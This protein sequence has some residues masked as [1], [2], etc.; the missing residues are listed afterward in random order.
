MCVCSGVL[1]GATPL[2]STVKSSV[3]AK[4]SENSCPRQSRFSMRVASSS[5]DRSNIPESARGRWCCRSLALGKCPFCDTSMPLNHDAHKDSKNWGEDHGWRWTGLGLRTA[6]VVS[7]C[8]GS[9]DWSAASE[10]GE[11][12]NT[13]SARLNLTADEKRRRRAA[14]NVAELRAILVP[15]HLEGC[16]WSLA[17]VHI[18]RRTI[19]YFD[20]LSLPVPK[21]LGQ[22]LTEFMAAE[23]TSFP[24][25][26]DLQVD[27]R[28]PQQKNWSD[29]GIF[30][31][32]YAECLVMDLPI[33]LDT[34]LSGIEE[35]RLA[36]ALA[37]LEGK[38]S[39]TSRET[40]YSDR[41]DLP[42]SQKWREDMKD[43]LSSM[44]TAKLTPEQKRKFKVAL[45]LGAGAYMSP[46]KEQSISAGCAKS[47]RK[48]HR[49]KVDPMKDLLVLAMVIGRF[50]EQPVST[51]EAEYYAGAS[52]ASDS[53]LLKEAIQFLTGKRTLF[54]Q[55]LHK[56]GKRIKLLLH[57]LGFQDENNEPEPCVHP[58][59]LSLFKDLGQT[60]QE[61]CAS[62]SL[63]ETGTSEE[64]EAAT[65]TAVV[66]KEL[67]D[68]M[69]KQGLNIRMLAEQIKELKGTVGTMTAEI[70][71]LRTEV[72][73]LQQR[74][75]EF[76]EEEEAAR[77]EYAKYFEEQEKYKQE[78]RADRDRLLEKEHRMEG[79]LGP[80]RSEI[81]EFS[82][83]AYFDAMTQEQEAQ[84]AMEENENEHYTQS[85]EYISEE[86][87]G[88]QWQEEEE[89]K[90]TGNLERG[91]ESKEPEKKPGQTQEEYDAERKE[92]L[93]KAR[94]AIAAKEAKRQ[95]QERGFKTPIDK[96]HDWKFYIDKEGN[97]WKQNYKTG[98]KIWWNYDYKYKHQK[99]KGKQAY[100]KAGKGHRP[101]EPFKPR[102][103]E[104][105]KYWE[106]MGKMEEEKR[107]KR[108][109]EKAV[110]EEKERKEQGA[111]ERLEKAAAE[112]EEKQKQ[113][114][115]LEKAAEENERREAERKAKEEEAAAAA[116][117]AAVKEEKARKAAAAE[118]EK[119]RKAAA[120]AAE[121][122]KKMEE[123]EAE[124]RKEQEANKEKKRIEELEKELAE[125]R[126]ET[127]SEAGSTKGEEGKTEKQ[128][129]ASSSS[130]DPETKAKGPP[131]PGQFQRG[132]PKFDEETDRNF[133]AVFPYDGN[134]YQW[135]WNGVNCFWYYYDLEQRC[136]HKQEGKDVKGKQ[137][138]LTQ[139]SRWLQAKGKKG[140]G[141]GKNKGKEEEEEDLAKHSPEYDYIE[142]GRQEAEGGQ[143]KAVKKGLQLH[144]RTDTP[145][146]LLC[147]TAPAH[148]NTPTWS[149]L[150][151]D[152]T[153]LGLWEEASKKAVSVLRTS[154]P[155]AGRRLSSVSTSRV[156][157][158]ESGDAKI[159]LHNPKENKW[160]RLRN[161]ND[162]DG[163]PHFGSWETFTAVDAG[164]GQVA[165]HCAAHN[166]YMRMPGAHALDTSSHRNAWDR[167]EGWLM[168]VAWRPA[169]WVERGALLRPGTTVALWNDVHKRYLRI[170]GHHDKTD[171]S[172][173][174]NKMA[175][176]PASWDWE[177]L[178]VVDA[179]YG[180]VALHNHVSNRFMKMGGHDFRARATGCKLLVGQW[181]LARVAE[182][183]GQAECWE[184]RFGLNL[185]FSSVALGPRD[186]I[187]SPQKNW[188]QLPPPVGWGSEKF[189]VVDAGGGK[190]ALHHA[191]HNRFLDAG[192]VSMCNHG[193]GCISPHKDGQAECWEERFGLNLAFSSVALGPRDMIRSPQKN[194]DQLPPPVGW[195]S[196]KFTVVDAG[197]GKVA[198]HHAEHN[199]FWDAG[200]VSMCN[201]GD[202][203]ISPHKAPDHLPGGWTWPVP[204]RGDMALPRP[205]VDTET[206]DT[207]TAAKQLADVEGKERSQLPDQR[208][209]KDRA[210]EHSPPTP[211]WGR[212]SDDEV[213][214]PEHS[215]QW[216]WGEAGRPSDRGNSTGIL[217]ERPRQEPAARREDGGGGARLTPNHMWLDVQ[218]V[219]E[220]MARAR[221][222]ELPDNRH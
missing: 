222:G 219:Q 159:G 153:S 110:A 91:E 185:A 114:E 151:G 47:S 8:T 147:G 76:I 186:M 174:L 20:S 163:A 126:G 45:L 178:R 78:L 24:G 21:L 165:L 146:R 56:Q 31:L 202:G 197:G 43:K 101:Q 117:A 149:G 3:Q 125:L 156:V 139:E 22:R 61:L 103:E 108:E 7:G 173:K 2:A 106:R 111:R 14:V 210:G 196:E 98:E 212:S 50:A 46:I 140:K 158:S 206:V 35:K 213:Q 143:L 53:I 218:R 104:D 142:A 107:R 141:K 80:T 132:A 135:K 81:D 34:F 87:A 171:A 15:L 137:V 198:L 59:M 199:R 207:T 124:K 69:E 75:S 57:W 116:K 96:S 193:D 130:E 221:R 148:G 122:R 40:S 4:R 166:K 162:M 44:D 168:L 138:C 71:N 129:Q 182:K 145:L 55:E 72:Q 133:Y 67:K 17:M 28:L 216:P 191:E 128:E 155:A 215:Q 5:S 70:G 189:T 74:W 144:D 93:A 118:E 157:A 36:I 169:E 200:F 83:R 119:K 115:T 92:L 64:E 194:W 73:E 160:I 85:F 27:N 23:V 86:E 99:G 127:R 190:V 10:G 89:P 16:H 88:P 217:A 201:H 18:P 54:L 51:G 39:L 38:L 167:G 188:D 177:L 48:K 94:A 79:H 180:Q 66:A 97:V 49:E 176:M 77:Q 134:D 181:A 187:R 195:G 42:M 183:D 184:E 209:R 13:C 19:S 62:H 154:C 26:L 161:N 9:D 6:H 30:M 12:L 112:E 150:E 204:Q 58:Q 175:D 60:V 109:E 52:A 211:D 68:L 1:Q 179:G 65:M 33:G 214:T 208:V 121:E 90:G 192:F 82:D 25:R 203:C 113:R 63:E 105:A 172:S 152:S 11:A 29:C 95:E 120:A 37:I 41:A 32:V 220:H 84:E 205:S 102:D 136:W 123:A 131:N 100:E 170:N 164:S